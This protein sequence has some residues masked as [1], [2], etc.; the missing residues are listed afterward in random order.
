MT[1][2]QIRALR[3]VYAARL[4]NSRELTRDQ[5]QNLFTADA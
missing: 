1:P 3:R 5:H 2:V 4:R